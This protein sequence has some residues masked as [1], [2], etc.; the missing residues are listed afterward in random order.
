MI[1]GDRAAV[2]EAA[3]AIGYVGANERE[4]R[5]RGVVDL[6]FLVC[7]PLRARGPYDF[8]RSQL[9]VRARD[10]GLDLMLRRG[11]LRAAAR[12][13]LS[14]PQARRV[15]PA[16]REV[17]G[18]SGRA[19]AARALPR[20]GGTADVRNSEA[21]PSVLITGCSSGIGRAT[22]IHLAARGY[23]VYATA[24][25]PETIEAL[26]E[27]GCRLLRLDVCDEASRQE[28]VCRVEAEQ[29]AVGVLVNNAGYGLTGAIEALPLD[30]VRSQFETNLSGPLR[31]AA[32]LALPGMR[33]RALGKDRQRELRGRSD[34]A[35]GDRSPQPVGTRPNAWIGPAGNAA[36]PSYSHAAP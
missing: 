27:H 4:D 14:P 17:T 31:L 3:V 25:R 19:R 10:A 24:R 6:I 28:A 12:D 7:E 22:V 36:F 35:R 32:Q 9:S 11:F 23:C 15:L 1:A 5:A 16:L 30:A 20:R 34:P 29:G 13:G 2:L 21:F 18:S 8:G 33:R 26:A